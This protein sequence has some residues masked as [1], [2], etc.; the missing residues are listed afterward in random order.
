[1]R[2][3]QFSEVD[4]REMLEQA[5]GLSA[6][7]EAGRWIVVSRWRGASWEVVVEPL[8]DEHLLLVITAYEVSR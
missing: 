1:M 3:R 2:D 7:L 6:S 8:F 5:T 4:L